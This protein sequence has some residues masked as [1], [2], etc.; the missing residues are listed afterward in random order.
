MTPAEEA[1]EKAH[2]ER[3]FDL[4][5]TGHQLM[6]IERALD[7]MLYEDAPQHMRNNG[8]ALEPGVDGEIDED[9]EEEAAYADTYPKVQEIEGIIRAAKFTR[10]DLR[11]E[12]QGADR[13]PG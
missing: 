1:A 5:F 9:D 6:L 12:D 2:N 10:R 11:G 13:P 7:A 3:I 4:K 8:E